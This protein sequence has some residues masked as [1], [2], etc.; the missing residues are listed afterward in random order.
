MVE[1]GKLNNGR[2]IPM[3]GFGTWQIEEG[4]KTYNAVTEAL[5]AGYRH[6]DTAQAYGNEAS[7][8]DAIKDSSVVREDIYLTTKVWNT[9]HTYDETLASIEES[10]KKLKVDYIDLVLIHWPNPKAVRENDGWKLRNKE[11]WRALESLQKD[12]KIRSIGVSNFM[13]HH[14]ESLLEEVEVI[15]AVNQIRLAPGLTQADLV[16]YCREKKILVQAYS[17]LGHG[18]AFNHP[19]IKEISDHYLGKSAAQVALRWSLD[20]GFLPLP[21]SQTPKHIQSNLNIFDFKLSEKDIKV[22]DQLEGI[23]DPVDPD[24]TNH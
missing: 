12:G 13:I 20:K 8:G 6:I 19:V 9:V 21:K 15:P 3:I 22:L 16:D 7:I 18:T 5:N 4:E 24:Q 11:V 1:R 14:L 10:M 17:P 2:N 23:I